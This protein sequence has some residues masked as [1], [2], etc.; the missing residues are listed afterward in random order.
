MIN[1]TTIVART[2]DYVNRSKVVRVLYA[3]NVQ[4]TRVSWIAH[5]LLRVRCYIANA[6]GAIVASADDVEP[7]Y[8]GADHEIDVELSGRFG[9]YNDYYTAACL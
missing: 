4:V 9:A 2:E 5:G 3:D 1:R 7:W 6:D 8:Y